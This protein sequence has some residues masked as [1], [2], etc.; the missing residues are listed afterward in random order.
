MKLPELFKNKYAPLAVC[1]LFVI[2]LVLWGVLFSAP[3]VD[4]STS[5]YFLNIGQGDSELIELAGGVHVLIDGGPSGKALLENLANVL[6]PT[7]KYIDLIVMTHPQ[8]DHFG[9]FI[10]V[11]KNYDVGAFISSGRKAD[12]S[13]YPE[14]H[15]L[16]EKNQVPYIQV[17][18]GDS[19]KYGD[20]TLSVLSP[21]SQDLLSGEFNDTAIVL[22]LETPEF[23]ALYTGDI[24]DNIEK[25]LAEKYD[26]DVDVLKVAHHGS[27]FSSSVEFLKEVSPQFSIIEVGKNTYGHPT[28]EALKRLK[29]F[30]DK[31]FRTD[32][33]GIIKIVMEDGKLV[34]K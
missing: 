34:R 12:V 5:L 14:L 16:L 7:K 15:D 21:S 4:G 27:K 23:K 30:G 6:P 29:E 19:I 8:V 32:K 1:A 11:L 17:K 20:V 26:I 18:E 3:G 22:L 33:E 10:D 9:G 25:K 31:I 13:A 24:G 2:D 28:A